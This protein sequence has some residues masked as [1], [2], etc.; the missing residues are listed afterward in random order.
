MWT[1]DS[2]KPYKTILLL[3]FLSTIL[4]QRWRSLHKVS[5]AADVHPDVEDLTGK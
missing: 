2:S 5:G 1:R 4:L 3:L